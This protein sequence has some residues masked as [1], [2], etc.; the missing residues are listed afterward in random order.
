MKKLESIFQLFLFF[1]ELFLF[2]FFQPLLRFLL[3]MLL[4]QLLLPLLLDTAE[5][6]AHFI[7]HAGQTI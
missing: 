5:I 2:F 7:G 3:R 6:G 1:P 4:F